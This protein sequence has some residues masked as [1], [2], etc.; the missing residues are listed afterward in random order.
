MIDCYFVLIFLI[1]G[2]A[3]KDA[4]ALYIINKN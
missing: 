4:N 2:T 1:R 3:V